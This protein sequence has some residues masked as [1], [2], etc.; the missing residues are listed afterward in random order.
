MNQQKGRMTFISLLITII[1]VYGGFAA[2]KYLRSYFAKKDLNKEVHDTLGVVRGGGFTGDKAEEVINGIL[3]KDGFT[4]IEVSVQMAE[5]TIT[6]HYKFELTTD[7]LFFKN[8][9]TVDVSEQMD[10]YGAF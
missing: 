9:E 7:Y 3:R 6:Y 2:F 5:G 1:L 10:T 4:P 8:R